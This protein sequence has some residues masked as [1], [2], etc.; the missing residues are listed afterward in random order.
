MRRDYLLFPWRVPF[1]VIF[2]TCRVV[3]CM[4]L[5]AGWGF[6]DARRAWRAWS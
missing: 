5:M 4:A 3:G 1:W 6:K 2:K